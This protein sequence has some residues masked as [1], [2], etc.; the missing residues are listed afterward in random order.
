MSGTT[1][2]ILTP[3]PI[4]PTARGAQE[5]S[6]PWQS[7]NQPAHSKLSAQISAMTAPGNTES[8][9]NNVQ[10]RFD[11]EG[12]LDNLEELIATFAAAMSL[13]GGLSRTDILRPPMNSVLLRW[14]EQIM[15]AKILDDT[16]DKPHLP[17]QKQK[18]RK[19][20]KQK[21]PRNLTRKETQDHSE[22]QHKRDHS[23]EY[24]YRLGAN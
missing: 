15:N 5:S 1:Q 9:A 2:Q 3:Q 10:A 12:I 20:K 4:L 13:A 18:V 14:L 6:T 16:P 11:A 21:K 24:A 19:R 7:N 23:Q 8:L 17:K 22:K